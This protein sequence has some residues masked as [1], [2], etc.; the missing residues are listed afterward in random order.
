M[1]PD[2]TFRVSPICPHQDVSL[3]SLGNYLTIEEIA[4]K[5]APSRMYED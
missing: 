3:L 1:V 2:C 4:Q 5:M